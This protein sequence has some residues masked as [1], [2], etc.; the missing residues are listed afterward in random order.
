MLAVCLVEQLLVNGPVINQ[1]SS[2]IPVRNNHSIMATVFAHKH[3]RNVLHAC[4]FKGKEPV[5]SF[6]HNWLAAE[7]VEFKNQIS[8]FILAHLSFLH[9]DFNR[10]CG[11]WVEIGAGAQPS[12][13]SNPAETWPAS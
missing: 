2:H 9:I 11:F 4:R 10:D 5:A 7:F 1:R 12:H 6:A 8:L 13:Y 3:F